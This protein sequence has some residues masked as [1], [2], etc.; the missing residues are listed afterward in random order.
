MKEILNRFQWSV[1]GTVTQIILKKYF[2]QR[3][4]YK[5]AYNT[6]KYILHLYVQYK[7]NFLLKGF[8]RFALENRLLV[9]KIFWLK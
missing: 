7:I 3:H 2:V 5:I 4:S 6:K 8:H 1:Y 9:T